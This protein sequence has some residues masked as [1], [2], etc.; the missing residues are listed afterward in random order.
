MITH[1]S[2][3]SLCICPGKLSQRNPP[4]MKKKRP[5]LCP[6]CVSPLSAAAQNKKCPKCC[7]T[8][9]LTTRRRLSDYA[10]EVYRFGYQYRLPFEEQLARNNDIRTHYSLPTPEPE[11]IATV[12]TIL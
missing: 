5:L 12:F 4:F 11:L 7:V 9:S 6:T 1:S 8:T 10:Y 3:W 2:D